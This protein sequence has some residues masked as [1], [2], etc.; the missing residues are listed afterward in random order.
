M[1]IAASGGHTHSS[2][3]MGTRVAFGEFIYLGL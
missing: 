1:T 2:L 3:V